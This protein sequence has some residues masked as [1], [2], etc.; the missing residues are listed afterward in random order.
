MYVQIFLGVRE[1]AGGRGELRGG[2]CLIS[3]FV[4]STKLSLIFFPGGLP[5]CHLFSCHSFVHLIITLN[6]KRLWLLLIT[7]CG[8]TLVVQMLQH[9]TTGKWTDTVRE[10][11]WQSL[12]EHAC[13]VDNQAAGTFL[14]TGLDKCTRLSLCML[15]GC[16]H[17]QIVG[18]PISHL[19]SG[20]ES[21]IC[22]GKLQV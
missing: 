9:A 14:Q 4:N 2:G 5:L 12:L 19:F 3:V 7:L 15:V 8:P 17:S 11:G 10:P 21:N 1:A 6:K 13:E 22:I 20:L 18:E 16:E